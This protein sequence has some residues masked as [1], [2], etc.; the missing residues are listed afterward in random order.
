MLAVQVQANGKGPWP[1]CLVGL[2]PFDGTI[3]WRRQVS[4]RRSLPPPDYDAG[5]VTVHHGQVY[6]A[7]GAGFVARCDARDGAVEWVSL[8]RPWSPGSS[9]L[10]GRKYRGVRVNFPPLLHAR[11]RGALA[12]TGNTIVLLPHDHGGVLAM[13]R[14]T[15]KVLWETFFIPGRQILGIRGQ[16][17]VFQ[18]GRWLGA[19]DVRSGKTL[20]QRD[21][22][23]GT[24]QTAALVGDEVRVLHDNAI[25][26]F[27]AETGEDRGQTALAEAPGTQRILLQDG[28]RVEVVQA[29]PAP[30][31]GGEAP[32]PTDGTG[33]PPAWARAWT[34]PRANPALWL[35]EQSGLPA[36]TA[37]VL[38]EQGLTRVRLGRGR[39]NR[40]EWARTLS[41]RPRCVSLHADVFAVGGAFRV[42]GL[43]PAT[44]E[45]RWATPVPF[46]AE[47]VGTGHGI[48]FAAQPRTQCHVAA[49][50]AAT[51]KR[52]WTRPVN[53]PRLQYDVNGT[54]VTVERRADGGPAV[55]IYRSRALFGDEGWQPGRIVLDA[56]SGKCL[57]FEKFRLPGSIKW[58]PYIRFAGKDVAY[59]SAEGRPHI[60]PTG[61]GADLAAGWTRRATPHT[62]SKTPTHVGLWWQGRRVYMQSKRTVWG[63]DAAAKK[64][65][66]FQVAPEPAPAIGP[67]GK[68]VPNKGAMRFCN[69]LDVLDA[70]GRL[71]VVSLQG[72]RA[73]RRDPV[74][75]EV[76]LAAFDR[77]TGASLGSRS[78]PGIVCAAPGQPGHPTRAVFHNGVLLVTDGN[79]LHVFTPAGT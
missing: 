11:R 61:G 52:L 66:A 42:E 29:L 31:A 38:S 35:P 3:R 20:W 22:P 39:T 1:I 58:P 48:V 47:T 25:R 51:G 72:G 41:G 33:G 46:R 13:D 67:D 30:H 6:C 68:P 71:F 19:L 18:G 69:V 57:D 24:C 70:D 27:R 59:I 54:R 76:V 55:C 37:C 50:D 64:E 77:N 45:T 65:T 44:G 9:R 32:A 15:G 26:R 79:G 28:R 34:L 40:V 4:V 53:G 60:R 8:Y 23:S 10:V 78:L 12:V 17:A 56:R 49:I 36:G 73:S 16:V 14:T 74:R 75:A 2:D 7:P 5:A 63:Y 43:N 62:K 21:L